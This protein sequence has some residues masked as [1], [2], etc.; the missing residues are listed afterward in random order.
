MSTYQEIGERI[1]KRRVSLG[2]T[3]SDLAQ[4]LNLSPD[5]RTTITKWE[6]GKALPRVDMIPLIC[7]VLKCDV[8]YLFSEYD[9]PTREIQ[10]V[11][12]CTGLSEKTATALR[13]L[14]DTSPSSNRKRKFLDILMEYDD[15]PYICL[16]FDKYLDEYKDRNN[17]DGYE[18]YKSG[19]NGQCQIASE[20][21]YQEFR[22][23]ELKNAEFAFLLS[24]SHFLDKAKDID[25]IK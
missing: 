24:W 20:K 2:M 21:E 19:M 22:A 15:F 17:P 7:D 3:Q 12:F 11:S 1:Q 14:A 9:Q 16:L 25:S 23:A 18:L 10:D 4:F 13:C 5:S 8:G 6:N